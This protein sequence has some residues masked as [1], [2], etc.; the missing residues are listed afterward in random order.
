MAGC[1]G[2]RLGLGGRGCATSLGPAREASSSQSRGPQTCPPTR[3]WV[4]QGRGLRTTT[5]AKPYMARR[6][7]HRLGVPGEDQP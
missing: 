5:T 3:K 7:W 6:P 1:G 4:W 2:G